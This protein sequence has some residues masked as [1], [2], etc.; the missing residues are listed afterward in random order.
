[1]KIYREHRQSELEHDLNMLEAFVQQNQSSS[2]KLY[3]LQ[4]Y[5]R[6]LIFEQFSVPV[7]AGEDYGCNSNGEKDIFIKAL[8]ETLGLDHYLQRKLGG[9]ISSSVVMQEMFGAKLSQTTAVKT[10]N[11]SSKAKSNKLK[12]G[13]ATPSIAPVADTSN[14]E[15]DNKLTD[16]RSRCSSYLAEGKIDFNR[17]FTSDEPGSTPSAAAALPIKL[18]ICSGSGEWAS[19]QVGSINFHF[20]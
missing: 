13:K 4:Y 2:C 17:I 9:V 20:G 16:I 1:M 7:A 19:L 15:L 3:S 6:V 18:E 5:E 11:S 14:I 12:N 8:V 10:S